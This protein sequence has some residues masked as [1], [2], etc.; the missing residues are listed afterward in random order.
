MR[1][2]QAARVLDMRQVL[3]EV[4]VPVTV[5]LQVLEGQKPEALDTRQR[6]RVQL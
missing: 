5:T 3:V 6:V 2:I 1:Q 4:L